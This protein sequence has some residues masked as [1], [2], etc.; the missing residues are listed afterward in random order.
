LSIA[1]C[2]RSMQPSS[3]TFNVFAHAPHMQAQHA[4]LDVDDQLA[5]V[6]SPLKASR[7]RVGPVSGCA[8]PASLSALCA[9]VSVP[10]ATRCIEEKRAAHTAAYFMSTAYHG[11]GPW[12]SSIRARLHPLTAM[13]RQRDR[14][15]RNATAAFPPSVAGGHATGHA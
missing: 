13:P 7:V 10:Q 8:V 15:L 14:R 2:M 1:H 11:R 3:H 4:S 5:V 6:Q 12:Q 9:A